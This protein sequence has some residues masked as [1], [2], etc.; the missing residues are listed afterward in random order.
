MI[1]DIDKIKKEI[2]DHIEIDITYPLLPGTLIKYIT[3]N[4]NDEE[5]FYL[6]GEYVKKG[7][8]KLF[9][10]QSNNTW[11]VKTNIRNNQNYI[12]YSSRF[13]IHKND[14]EEKKIK[15]NEE[16][17]Y[18]EIIKKQQQVIDKLSNQVINY[19]KTINKQNIQIKNL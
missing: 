14:L 10:R 3:L 9:I 1:Q 15:N 19:Q 12:I 18:E 4:I 13:F 8:E 2:K 17:K 11:A 16:K 5:S 6:G 7:N